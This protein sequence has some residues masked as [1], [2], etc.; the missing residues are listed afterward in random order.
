MYLNVTA[1]TR[2]T[3]LLKLM[4]ELRC[5]RVGVRLKVTQLMGAWSRTGLRASDLSDALNESLEAGVLDFSATGADVS[6]ALTFAGASW[7]DSADGKRE[8]AAERPTL[9]AAQQRHL[10]N[11]DGRKADWLERRMRAA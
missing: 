4:I 6:V 8:I 11:G 5:L 9:E 1:A 7:I 10:N 3:A 2:R